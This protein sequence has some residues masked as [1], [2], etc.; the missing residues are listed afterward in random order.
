M[1]EC[2][3]TQD[4]RRLARGGESEQDALPSIPLRF[5]TL[6]LTTCCNLR[7]RYCYVGEAR[8]GE[9]MTAAVARRAIDLIAGGEHEG[10]VTIELAG[11]EPL[12]NWDVLVEVVDYA[13][14]AYPWARIALQTNGLL[15]GDVVYP[16]DVVYPH[17]PKIAF[18]AE[19][20]VGLAVSLDGVAAVNDR[21]RGGT[22]QVLRELKL[23]SDHGVGVNVTAVLT[24]ESITRIPE[25]LLLCAGLSC[26]R[27]VNLDIVH[28][29][30]RDGW[31]MVPDKAQIKTMVAALPEVLAMINARRFPPLKVREFEKAY[32]QP[33]DGAERPYCHAAQGLAAAVT[34]EGDL[35]P[36]ASLVGVEGY[37]AGTV[38]R[39]EPA[40]LAL[41]ADPSGTRP[42][43]QACM[44]CELRAI[45]R[46]GCP[47]RRVAYNGSAAERCVPECT[48]Y[49]EIYRTVRAYD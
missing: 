39:P 34:P 26:V 48:L 8:H 36:C 27:V 29:L 30:G 42:Y 6:L 44:M 10:R 12:L 41:L 2:A 49:R 25:L 3:L 38:W 24:R 22:K 45:C 16:R 9:P 47:S 1:S 37:R 11:G 18:L 5:L 46:G 20:G 13:E 35:Y 15:L 32:R 4:D 33:D 19:H 23:L 28:P 21:Q 7:C 40:R 43:P 17:A 31:G 14:A